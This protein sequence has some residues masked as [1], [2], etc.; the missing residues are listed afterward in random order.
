[1]PRPQA[2]FQAQTIRPP[3]S[4]PD[5]R[6]GQSGGATWKGDWQSGEGADLWRLRRWRHHIGSHDVPVFCAAGS[7]TSTTTSP[8]AIPKGTAFRKPVFCMLPNKKYRWS[9]YSIAGSKH[10]KNQDGQDLGIDFII[11]DHHN[12]ADTILKLLQFS[13]LKDWIAAIRT[14]NFRV[15][16]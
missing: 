14:R 7:K 16:V 12:P 10:R 6:H 15:A 11:C 2:F 8:I 9:L 3:R 5:E 4:I 1:M 13:I